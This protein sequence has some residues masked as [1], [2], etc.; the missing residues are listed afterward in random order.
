MLKI[1]TKYGLCMKCGEYFSIK[2][3]KKCMKGHRC[4]PE[5]RPL[6]NA[7]VVIALISS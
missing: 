3:V 5:L 4:Y 7:V 1:Y 6:L 2:P